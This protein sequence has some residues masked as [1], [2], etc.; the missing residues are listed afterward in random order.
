[1]QEEEREIR[2]YEARVRLLEDRIAE[3]RLSRRVLMDLLERARQEQMAMEKENLRLR[4]QN[5]VFSRRLW[6][7]NTRLVKENQENL[8]A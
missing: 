8:N 2:A 1:M 6:Q 5:A 4:K 7:Q 3:L